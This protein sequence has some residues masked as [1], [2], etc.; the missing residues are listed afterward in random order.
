MKRI[1]KGLV[2]LIMGSYFWLIFNQARYSHVHY[3]DGHQILTHAHP[4]VPDKDHHSPIQSHSHSAG[5]AFF[6]N[7][8]TTF[9]IDTVGEFISLTLFVYYLSVFFI[10]YPFRIHSFRLDSGES[11]APPVTE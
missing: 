6:L 4:Y 9:K 7:L 2:F 5:L 8:I 10:P 1:A 3:I 11:R